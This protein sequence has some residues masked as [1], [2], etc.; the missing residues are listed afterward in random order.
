MFLIVVGG[1]VCKLPAGEYF[2]EKALVER[3]PRTAT[4][5]AHGT[6]KCA[7]LSIAGFERLMVSKFPRKNDNSDFPSKTR[8]F[9]G[10][11]GIS[12][13]P[14]RHMVEISPPRWQR[15]RAKWTCGERIPPQQRKYSSAKMTVAS[16]YLEIF[17]QGAPA[18]PTIHY[19]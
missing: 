9:L 12:P 11:N 7:A 4:V 6:V 13:P 19:L 15:Y 16:L 1:L 5:K 10:K 14:K 8:V 3:T 17:L 18:P 2:G